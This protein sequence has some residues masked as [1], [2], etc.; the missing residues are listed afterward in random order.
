M[1]S[2]FE[3]KVTSRENKMRIEA[4]KL[5][6]TIKDIESRI[7]V[8]IDNG[9]SYMNINPELSCLSEVVKY[10]DALG[11]ETIGVYLNNEKKVYIV[12]DEEVW[13]KEIGLTETTVLK[14]KTFLKEN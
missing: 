11:Y 12:W 13:A 6:R 8:A 14:A 9:W 3:A 7:L 10:F 2:A 4:K 5:E 1:I